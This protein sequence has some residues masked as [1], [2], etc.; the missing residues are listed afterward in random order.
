MS[1]E[2]KKEE[3]LS[4]ICIPHWTY[5]CLTS[6]RSSYFIQLFYDPLKGIARFTFLCKFNCLRSFDI[7]RLHRTVE[8]YHGAPTLLRHCLQSSHCGAV[9]WGTNSAL[10]SPAVI[11]QWCCSTGNQHCF[12]IAPM[13]SHG[14]AVPQGINTAS[15]F[16]AI[17][18]QWRC[19]GHQRSFNIACRCRSFE[20]YYGAPTRLQYCLPSLHYRAV[21]RGT[22]AA[23]TLPAIITL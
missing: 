11:A 23:S 21:P 6:R 17:I 2:L 12:D 20:Q 5:C 4:L 22:N 15:K 19:T 9:L 18:A 16:P 1:F 8:Q 10:T 14:G 3:A 7:A 13:S